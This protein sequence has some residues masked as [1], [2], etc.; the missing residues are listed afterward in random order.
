MAS[1][2]SRKSRSKSAFIQT[3]PLFS[4][5]QVQRDSLSATKNAYLS[6]LN[7]RYIIY[8]QYSVSGFVIL[9]LTKSCE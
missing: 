9:K 3:W 1:L 7:R 2:V 4:H 8:F 6:C 5:F